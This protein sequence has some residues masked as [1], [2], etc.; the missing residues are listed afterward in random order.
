[1]KTRT[2]LDEL[3][4]EFDALDECDGGGCGD[5]GGCDCGGAGTGTADVL[6]PGGAEDGKGCMGPGDFHVPFPVMPCLVRWPANW[7]GGSKKKKRRKNDAPAAKPGLN[8][9]AKGL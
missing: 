4:E 7:L 5:G 3:L 2:I 6:G 9:Y 1:M 8:P